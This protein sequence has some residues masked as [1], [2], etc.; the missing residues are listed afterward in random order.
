MAVWDICFCPCG[1]K[2]EY[3]IPMKYYGGR[4]CVTRLSLWSARKAGHS[5]AGCVTERRGVRCY[6]VL[7]GDL[8]TECS[9]LNFSQM[10]VNL[11]RRGLINKLIL[12]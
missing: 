5:Y 10:S 6:I 8:T 1:P 3:I 11:L 7:Q 2:N 4:M 12:L 9:G